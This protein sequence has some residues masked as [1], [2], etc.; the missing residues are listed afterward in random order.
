MQVEL[1]NID[2]IKPYDRNPRLNDAAVD[3]VAKSPSVKVKAKIYKGNYLVTSDGRVFTMTFKGK[4]RIQMQRLRDNSH[5][6]LRASIHMRDEY[7]HRIVARCFVE[8]PHEYLEVNHKDGNKTNNN[9]SNLEWCTRTENNRHAFRIGLRTNAE[10]S[11]IA[12]CPR[13]SQRLFA[14]DTIIN[15]RAMIQAGLSDRKIAKNLNCS[16]GSI[17]QIRTE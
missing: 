5:G 7:V 3:A 4:L 1:K 8:N 14:D 13:P 6:Y 10:M 9:T 16:H 11:L 12:R 15:I 2:E 17:Y